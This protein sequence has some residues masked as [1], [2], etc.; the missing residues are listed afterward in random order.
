MI[1]YLT[2]AYVKKYM[3]DKADDLKLNRRL[4]A[5]SFALNI[6][7]ICLINILGGRIGA[8]QG[9]LMHSNTIQNPFVIVMAI[10]SFNLFRNKHF[11]NET[12]NAMAGLT[13]YVYII[14]E[15]ILF[16][17]YIRPWIWDRMLKSFG[18]EHILVCALCFAA[19][20]YVC[21]FAVGKIYCMTIGRMLIAGMAKRA[22]S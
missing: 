12:V 21:S 10:T 3:A 8:L 17:T 15:N 2:V 18:Y 9:M 4:F 5:A 1:I 13:L 14:H 20:L 6:A 22:D 7:I 16:R 19:V 11:H